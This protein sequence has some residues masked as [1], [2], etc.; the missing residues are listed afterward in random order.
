M[1]AGFKSHPVYFLMTFLSVQK[2][3]VVGT[4]ERGKSEISYVRRNYTSTS[5]L[6]VSG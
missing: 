1:G 4:E 5:G 6:T 2:Q 3:I